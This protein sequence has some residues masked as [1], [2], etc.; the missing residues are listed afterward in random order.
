MGCLN[1]SQV[2]AR[3]SNQKKEWAIEEDAGSE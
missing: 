2:S 1:N 3:I